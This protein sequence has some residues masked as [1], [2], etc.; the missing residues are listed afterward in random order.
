MT[1]QLFDFDKIQSVM[2][3]ESFVFHVYFICIGLYSQCKVM[4]TRSL[5]KAEVTSKTSGSLPGGLKGRRQNSKD[6]VTNLP[7][8]L[9][10]SAN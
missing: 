3:V 5:I 4:K 6:V 7:L 8:K 9:A 1:H 10:T 2:Y